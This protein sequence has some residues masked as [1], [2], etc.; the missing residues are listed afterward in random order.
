MDASQW[1]IAV[2]LSQLDNRKQE[3]LI[4]FYSRKLM[5]VEQNYDIYNKK[6]LVIID[7]FKY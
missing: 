7:I 3:K 4:I 1:I 6:L 5:P 2:Y